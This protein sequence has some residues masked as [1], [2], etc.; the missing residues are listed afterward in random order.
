MSFDPLAAHVE[1]LAH[2]YG[3]DIDPFA[4]QL[5]MTCFVGTCIFA[6]VTPGFLECAVC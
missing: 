3:R 2:I 6:D 1:A 5:G 4:V